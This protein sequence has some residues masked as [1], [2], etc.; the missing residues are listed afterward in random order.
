MYIHYTQGTLI[1]KTSNRLLQIDKMAQRRA[2]WQHKL[3][4]IH[5]L[6]DESVAMSNI[7]PLDS[8]SEDVS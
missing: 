7:E 5:I 1:H 2:Y 6:S 8:A 4:I 3:Y